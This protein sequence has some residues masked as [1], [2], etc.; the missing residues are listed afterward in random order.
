MTRI[1]DI[2]VW[3]KNILAPNLIHPLKPNQDNLISDD[4]SYL[5]GNAIIKQKRIKQG[6]NSNENVFKSY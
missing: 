5:F 4:S 6:N 1:N 2:F 3:S